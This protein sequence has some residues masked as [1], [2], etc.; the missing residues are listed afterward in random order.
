MP[1]PDQHLNCRNRRTACWCT[2][3][4]GARIVTREVLV[5]LGWI[6]AIFPRAGNILVVLLDSAECMASEL[7]IKD[8]A[9]LSPNHST[10]QV[11]GVAALFLNRRSRTARSSRTFSGIATIMRLGPTL[12]LRM[13]NCC[14]R[15]TSNN[16][17]IF[18]VCSA[19]PN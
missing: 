17:G 9:D 14:F 11:A 3:R 15:S 1:E 2:D 13:M 8:K 4:A 12:A 18:F 7:K 19:A 5:S 10:N 16:A 6:S